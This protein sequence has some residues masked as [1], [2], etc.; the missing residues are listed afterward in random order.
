M[1]G[2]KMWC[3]HIIVAQEISCVGCFL[4]HVMRWESTFFLQVWGYVLEE[5]DCLELGVVTKW[6]MFDTLVDVIFKIIIKVD[7]HDF[8]LAFKWVSNKSL[9][10]KIK[11][12]KKQQTFIIKRIIKEQCK[13]LQN[14]L[15]VNN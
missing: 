7:W 1:G 3:M 5:V 2:T 14:Q 9:K 4:F 13:C 6:E 10:D 12:I 11:A 8:F 15:D